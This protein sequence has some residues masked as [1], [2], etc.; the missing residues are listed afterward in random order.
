MSNDVLDHEE[1]SLANATLL[2]TS[3]VPSQPLSRLHRDADFNQNGVGAIEDVL[4]DPLVGHFN[5]V[6][7][8]GHD[9]GY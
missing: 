5:G 1:I 2:S 4:Y 8:I 3:G 7:L 6:T 9:N